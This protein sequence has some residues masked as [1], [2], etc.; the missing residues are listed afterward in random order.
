MKGKA[1]GDALMNAA[2][3][4]N[5]RESAGHVVAGSPIIGKAE[6]SGSLAVVKAVYHLA[7]GEVVRLT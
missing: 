7:S 6:E 2:V 5:A 3:E 1:S 4:A